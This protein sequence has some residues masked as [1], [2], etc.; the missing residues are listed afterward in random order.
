MFGVY[1]IKIIYTAIIFMSKFCIKRTYIVSI[2]CPCGIVRSQH[3]PRITISTSPTDL[4]NAELYNNLPKTNEIICLT[5]IGPAVK[6]SNSKYHL[7]D[8]T[9]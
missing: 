5:R 3:T 1:E 7:P 9:A 2:E 4:N 8:V 6:T